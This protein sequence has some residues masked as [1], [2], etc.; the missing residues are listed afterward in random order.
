MAAAATAAAAGGGTGAVV[1]GGA[2][3]LPPDHEMIKEGKASIIFSKKN[4]GTSHTQ[5]LFIL[6]SD[7]W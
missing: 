7:L 3:V 5:Q 4:R 2:G 6:I 1:T